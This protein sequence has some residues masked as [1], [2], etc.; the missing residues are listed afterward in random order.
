M[1]FVLIS[2]THAQ[3]RALTLPM[4]DVIIHA[5]D[6]SRRGEESE[7]V[8][9]LNWFTCLD[10]QHKIFIAGNHDFYFER[11]SE[12]RIKEII[13][14]NITYLCDSGTTIN[15]LKIWGSPI[16]PWFYNWAFNRRRGEQIKHHWDLIPADTDILITHGPVF[17]KL[18]RTM[19]GHKAGCEELLEKVQKVNPKIHICGHIHE[20]YG[21]IS[22][23]ETHYVNASVLN[24][25]YLLI[26]EPI[27]FEI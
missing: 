21:Q 24:E 11:N 16:T 8:D 9:F 10:F 5:G 25:N 27:V 18:D 3:H 6:I 4:G 22:D 20:A 26:N 23:A 12:D 14:E 7:I 19:V 2:D 1:Q 13:P 17:G 15:K